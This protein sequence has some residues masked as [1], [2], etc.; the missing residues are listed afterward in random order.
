MPS[1]DDVLRVRASFPL[2]RAT[3]EMQAVARF[4]S[5]HGIWA[6]WCLVTDGVMFLRMLADGRPDTLP[7]EMRLFL[8]SSG[9]EAQVD[10]EEVAD[11][12]TEASMRGLSLLL[13]Q[14]RQAS[15]DPFARGVLRAPGV[16]RL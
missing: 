10:L 15:Q 12:E 9:I 7:D 11:A 6:V 16:A 14:F 13:E 8:D 4:A 2:H 1:S 5:L 3:P